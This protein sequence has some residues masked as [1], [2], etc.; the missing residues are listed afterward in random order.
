MVDQGNNDLQNPTI[1]PEKFVSDRPGGPKLYKSNHMAGVGDENPTEQEP[2]SILLTDR[3][4]L[5][6]DEQA[7]YPN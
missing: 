5:N 7:H 4:L 3:P 6:N 1:E 2:D